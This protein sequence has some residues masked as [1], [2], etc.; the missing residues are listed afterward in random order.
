MILR[1]EDNCAL[2]TVDRVRDDESGTLLV[3]LLI[4]LTMLSVAVGA[5]ISVFAADVFSLRHASIEGNATA[6]ADDQME[7]LKTLPYSSLKLNTATMPGAGDLYVS[8]PPTNLT[9]SQQA[10]ITSG[11]IGGGTIAPTQNVTGP[12]NRTYRVDTYIFQNAPSGGENLLQITIA[13]RRVDAGTAGAIMGQATSAFDLAST[14]L[15]S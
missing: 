5:L 7:G 9:G 14:R 11:Q 2:G 10:A 3:E 1:R 15:A 8:S 4:A 6:I 12:D 13:V